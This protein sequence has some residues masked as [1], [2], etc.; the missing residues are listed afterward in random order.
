MGR[1]DTES[2]IEDPTIYWHGILPRQDLD[3]DA[4]ARRDAI[5]N[6][7]KAYDWRVLLRL[8]ENAPDLV[9][10]WRPGGDS[11]YAP[12]HQAAHGGA[13]TAIV[14][15]LLQLGAWR[16]LR[17]SERQRPLDIARERGHDHLF[18]LLEPRPVHRV[19]AELLE[20]M[21]GHF[22]AVIR[23]RIDDLVGEPRKLRLPELAPLTEY[24]SAVFW[25][26]V[27]GMYGG[28]SYSMAFRGTKPTMTV[29]SWSRVID[30]SEQRHEI[31]ADEARLVE[32]GG[33]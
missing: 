17:T 30:G 33:V 25:F 15:K 24:P 31:T 12:L 7:A 23:S 22:H 10:A 16:T 29:S 6:A 19:A 11:W 1:D 18:A 2:S 4:L 14:D 9:N 28:F 20:R 3:E 13:P 21:Q 8:L 27:P 32:E 5:S 26:A